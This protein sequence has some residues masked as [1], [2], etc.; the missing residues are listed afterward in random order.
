LT[1]VGPPL[2]G[3]YRLPFLFVGLVVALLLTTV[4]LERKRE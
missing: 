1:P 4:P 3:A 2:W